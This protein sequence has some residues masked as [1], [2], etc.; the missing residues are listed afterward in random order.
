MNSSPPPPHPQRG[1]L[2]QFTAKLSLAR[3]QVTGSRGWG[4]MV[5]S[6]CP[7]RGLQVVAKTSALPDL[8]SEADQ[9]P[10]TLEEK[11]QIPY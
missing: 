7:G 10:K 2:R 3:G 1:W 4:Q 9:K 5:A 11:S 8:Y 6:G